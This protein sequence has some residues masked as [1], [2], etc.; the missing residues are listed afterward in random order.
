MQVNH[1]FINVFVYR[2]T[3]I[4]VELQDTSKS[5]N[6][7]SFWV[8]LQELDPQWLTPSPT[9]TVTRAGPIFPIHLSLLSFICIFF[10]GMAKLG[11][12]VLENLDKD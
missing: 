5:L 6:Y 12:I 2:H 7:S 4:T 1:I 8:H 3:W 11:C 10:S 9:M